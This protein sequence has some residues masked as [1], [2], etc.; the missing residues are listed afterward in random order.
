MCYWILKRVMR[1]ALQLYFGRIEIVGLDGLPHG[2]KILV[3][4]HQN[5]FLDALIIGAFTP[6]SHYYLTRADIFKPWTLFFFRQLHMIPIY[7]IRDGFS[8]LSRNDI[9]FQSCH[10]A[11]ARGESVMIFPEGNHGEHHYLRPLTKGMARIALSSNIDLLHVQPIGLNFFHHRHPRRKLLI[12][13]GQPIAVRQQSVTPESLKKLTRMTEARMKEC[14]LIPDPRA[15]YKMYAADLYRLEN[16]KI[17]W[18]ELKKGKRAPIKSRPPRVGL[19]PLE[20]LMWLPNVIPLLILQRVLKLFED[21]VFWASMKLVV[22]VVLLPLWWTL[23]F[24]VTMR[25]VHQ[26]WGLVAVSVAVAS[27]FLR[28][29]LRNQ[30]SISS[31]N[32]FRS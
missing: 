29:W 25:M 26:I 22:M 30:F 23:L 1:W 2:P 15:D 6:G 8:K 9:T 12:V 13:Y 20:W 14:L 11:L 10:Q 16:E 4:N 17:T 18:L 19:K 24:L 27:L 32:S 28:T 21:R 7:R 31:R 3:S 5:A